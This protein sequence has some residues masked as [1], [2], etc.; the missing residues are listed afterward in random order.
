[1]EVGSAD[2]DPFRRATVTAWPIRAMVEH[3]Q[4]A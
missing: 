1:M 3:K 2:V 4:T